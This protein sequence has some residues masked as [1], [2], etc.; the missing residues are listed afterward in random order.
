MIINI[1]RIKFT[2]NKPVSVI[3]NIIMI[4]VQIM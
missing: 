3:S 4:E 2:H 1:T